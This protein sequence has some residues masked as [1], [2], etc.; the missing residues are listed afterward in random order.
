[1]TKAKRPNPSPTKLWPQNRRAEWLA[2]R[3]CS[4]YISDVPAVHHLL[5][6]I[7]RKPGFYLEE[8]SLSALK[9]Y[10]SGYESA[11]GLHRIKEDWP[12]PEDFNAWVAYR[13]HYKESTSGW[14][15]M[16]LEV[17]HAEDAGFA[18]LFELLDEYA[19]REPHIVARLVGHQR[20]YKSGPK[21]KERMERIPDVSLVTF[22]DD[23][24][25]IVI[26]DKPGRHSFCRNRFF[27]S[28][29]W[30]L[31]L[32][33]VDQSRLTVLDQEAFDRWVKDAKPGDSPNAG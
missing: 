3:F 14:R 25:F 1:M 17:T 27:P 24:G 12:L 13:L 28:L 32:V 6:A 26:A 22:T 11:L 2:F 23:P 20:H 5:D 10:I 4:F 33:G 15:N 21:G 16:I 8:R 7:R 19:R 18:R 29:D 30:F 31:S 9:H